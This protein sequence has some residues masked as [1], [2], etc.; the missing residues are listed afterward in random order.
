M[1]TS[2]HSTWTT[3][4]VMH[5]ALMLQVA[6]NA[7]VM[8]DIMEMESTATTLMNAVQKTTAQPIVTVSTLKARTLVLVKVDLVAT[9]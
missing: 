6:L 4:H 7:I 8:S 2:A 5:H 3:V 9:V 1:S